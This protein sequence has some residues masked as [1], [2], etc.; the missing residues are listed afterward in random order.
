MSADKSSLIFPML[1]LKD[2]ALN[3]G[4]N[5]VYIAGL[6]NDTFCAHCPGLS[7]NN[8]A[9]LIIL[10]GTYNAC[11]ILYYSRLIFGNTLKI[12]SKECLVVHIYMGENRYERTVYHIS[13]IQKS[14]HSAFK[15][16]EV[17]LLIKKGKKSQSRLYLE[18]RGCRQSFSS[19]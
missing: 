17:C 15:K 5:P 9:Y 19:H 3:R 7:L 2:C 6:K 18:G 12:R 11:T 16:Y 10:N 14:T 8:L 4:L 13:C 1:K